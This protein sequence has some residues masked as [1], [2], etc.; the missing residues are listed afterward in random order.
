[1]MRSEL[2][3]ETRLGILITQKQDGRGQGVPVWFDWDGEYLRCFAARDSK[4]INRLKR[5]SR[6]SLLVTNQVGEAEA[7]V[8][9]D[10]EFSVLDEGGLALAEKL[11]A[12]Y[13]DLENPEFAA[14]LAEWQAFPDVFVL[15][16]MKPDKV[17][18]GS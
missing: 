9:F 10:G 11:A 12:R 1:M 4:K 18:T 13:W 5:D 2:L 8:A 6:A 17:R 7:W 16:E 3:N 14:K 15:L